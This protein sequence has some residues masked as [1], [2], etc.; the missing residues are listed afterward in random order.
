[1]IRSED[2]QM[3]IGGKYLFLGPAL[4][5]ELQNGEGHAAMRIIVSFSHLWLTSRCL[6][7]VNTAFALPRG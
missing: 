4:E 7:F 3:V 2:S 6:M 5:I 1:M